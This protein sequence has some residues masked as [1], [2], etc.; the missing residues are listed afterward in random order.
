MTRSNRIFLISIVALSLF[1]TSAQ[2]ITDSSNQGVEKST[3]DDIS[4]S[5]PID[6]SFVKLIVRSISGHPNIRRIIVDSD[7][8]DAEAALQLAQIIHERGWDVVV[9]NK[10]LSACAKYIFP[11]GKHKIVSPNSWVGIH[12]TRRKFQRADGSI[13][14][15]SGNEIAKNMELENIDPVSTDAARKREAAAV[16]FYR[17]LNLS[18]VLLQDFAD[19]ISSRKRVLGVEN[20]NDFPDVRGCPRYMAWALNK[21]QLE[22]MGVTGIDNFW[23]PRNKEEET[24]LY[25]DK[26]LPPGSIYIGDAGKLSTFCKGPKLGWLKRL[27]LRSEQ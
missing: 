14:Y 2:A 9:R 26:L 15:V 24:M 21:K 4:I 6:G 25:K 7:G 17:S 13:Y 5:G 18:S 22:E 10:C 11:A 19:Y 23:F 8:G 3:G 12:E 1:L 27:F 16:G 20:V